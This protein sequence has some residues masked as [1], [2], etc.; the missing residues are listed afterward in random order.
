MH[1]GLTEVVRFTRVEPEQPLG[2]YEVRYWDPEEGAFGE[3][4]Y[5]YQ[6]RTTFPWG[7]G[8]RAQLSGL[9]NVPDED[10]TL[11]SGARWPESGS[12]VLDFTADTGP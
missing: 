7:A 6:G 8:L 5:R 10:F 1:V 9:D 12:A 11:L 4:A 3:T 2:I